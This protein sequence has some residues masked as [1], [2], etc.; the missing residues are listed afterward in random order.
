MSL[1]R[2]RNC[3]DVELEE[4]KSDFIDA[5]YRLFSRQLCWTLVLCGRTKLSKRKQCGKCCEHYLNLNCD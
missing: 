2:A 4:V 3:L 1:D 5:V